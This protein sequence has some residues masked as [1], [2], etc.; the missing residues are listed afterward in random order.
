MVHLFWFVLLLAQSSASVSEPTGLTFTTRISTRDLFGGTKQVFSS[1]STVYLQGDRK[2]TEYPK[3]GTH[4]LDGSYQPSLVNILR[5]DLHK[6]YRLNMDTREYEDGPYGDPRIPPTL[7]VGAAMPI[8]GDMPS[9][10]PKIR[11]ETDT[12]DTGERKEMFGHTARHVITTI[13]SIPVENSQPESSETVMD[14]WYIDLNTDA[15]CQNLAAMTK[16][17][18]EL[19]RSGKASSNATFVETGEPETGFVL[20]MK[21]ITKTTVSYPGEPNRVITSET[22]TRVT[23]FEEKP[24]DPALFEIPD[25]F[26]WVISLQHGQ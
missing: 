6:F 14:G 4:Y 15:S 23:K 17:I 3:N 25:G 10:L 19:R 26:H 21:M 8:Q 24:L 18:T 16:R 12:K 20:Q 22:D 1:E 7:R 13:K 2:R 9:G 11:I 5:C